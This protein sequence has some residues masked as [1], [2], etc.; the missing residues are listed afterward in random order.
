MNELRAP[1]QVDNL[2][3]KPCLFYP[4]DCFKSVFW[5]MIMALCLLITCLIVPFNMAFSEELDQIDWF[6]QFVLVIDIFFSL[7]I[8]I[9]FNTA[10][11][12]NDEVMELEDDRKEIACIYLKGWFLIDLLSVIPFD[13]LVN[14][15]TPKN[16]AFE[17]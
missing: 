16:S 11:L 12:I 5:D 10:I 17:S 4:Q 14:T 15:L 9:N 6:I 13:V 8:L 7:D 1:D 2:H 3:R